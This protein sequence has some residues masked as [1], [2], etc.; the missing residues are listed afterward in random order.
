SQVP[1]SPVISKWQGDLLNDVSPD[2]PHDV[3][4]RIRFEDHAE[5]R[6]LVFQY[7]NG[8]SDRKLITETIGG[9]VAIDDFD[10]DL[11]SD[12]FLPQGIPV[13][14]GRPLTTTHDVLFR[15]THNGR[16]HDVSRLANVCDAANASVQP[17]HGLGCTVA[18]FDNDGFRDLFVCNLGVNHLYRNNGDGT[19]SLVESDAIGQSRECTSSAAFCDLNADGDP[20]LYVVNYVSDWNRVCKNADGLPATCDPRQFTGGQD[21]LYLNNGNGDFVDITDSAGIVNPDGKGLGVVVADMDQDGRPDLYIAN[22]GV[23]NSLFLN[24]S[25]ADGVSFVES[26][27]QNGVAVGADGRSEAGM[28]IAC[29]D[30]DGNATPDLVVTNFYREPNRLYLNYGAALFR[31]QTHE[32]SLDAVSRETLGFGIQPIDVDLIGTTDLVIMNGDIDDYSSSGRPW[33]MKPQL[34]LNISNQRF[35]DV[36]SSA[37]TVF[38]Q[39]VL[40]RGLASGDLNQDGITDLIAVCHDRPVLLLTNL[41]PALPQAVSLKLT[42]TTGNRDSFGAVIQCQGQRTLTYWVNAGDGYASSNSNWL[43]VPA[44]AVERGVVIRSQH[45]EESVQISPETD[46]VML[47]E[48]AAG[49]RWRAVELPRGK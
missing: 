8:A 22:D 15:Q 31:D 10:Q 37:G 44:Q 16:F 3:S 46:R 42:G 18:D 33:K 45:S 7:E 23:P 48:G 27:M 5:Q 38:Q 4:S 43:T 28:G 29:A 30:F 39:A 12:V 14:S 2:A 26:G 1:Q 34:L 17:G 6:G 47:I 41:T 35:S 40:G 25:D 36:S 49:K 9:G 19:F 20:D 13:G 21:R 11:L 24:R 32:W